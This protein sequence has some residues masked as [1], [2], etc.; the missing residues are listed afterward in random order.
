MPARRHVA[1][2]AA[3]LLLTTAC[4]AGAGGTPTPA[5]TP[6]PDRPAPSSPTAI[7]DLDGDGAADLVAVD[8]GHAPD[9]PEDPEPQREGAVEVALATG[10]TRRLPMSELG[11]DWSDST[12]FGAGRL[13]ADLNLDGYADLLVSDPTPEPEG[14]SRGALYVLWGGADGLSPSRFA[15]L[16][17]G[18]RESFTG[19]SLALVQS[20]RRTL[21]VGTRHAP[22][23]GVALYP[24]AG[25]GGLGTPV[26]LD[27][28]TVGLPGSLGGYGEFG[29]VLAAGGSVLAIGDPS[30]DVAGATGAGSVTLLRLEV[31]GFAPQ[32]LSEASDKVPGAAEEGDR[33]GSAVSAYGDLL[34]IGAPGEDVDGHADA[35]R[36]YAF[37]LTGDAAVLLAELGQDSADVPGEAGDGH[38]FGDTVTVF[39]PCQAAAGLLVGSP[40]EG[41]VGTEGAAGALHLIG[42]EEGCASRTLLPAGS[43]GPAEGRAGSVAV[44]RASVPGAAEAVA[45]RLQ[46]G[47]VAVLPPPFDGIAA[48]HSLRGD[49]VAPPG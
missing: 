13:I 39:R 37:R 36:V 49:L 32:T 34:A 30:A 27:R 22:G 15:T 24:V 14:D 40:G 10:V 6:P 33:F 35:G 45:A 44:L 23:G 42:L 16:A 12:Q 7:A 41:A 31:P 8:R 29:S 4:S 19:W 26:L 2:I 9:D 25:D 38:G 5:A 48:R 18:A 3:T 43:A 21:A 46:R 1:A 47:G 28:G 20:P 11:L 17:R